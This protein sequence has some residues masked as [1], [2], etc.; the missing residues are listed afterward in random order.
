MFA[1]KPKFLPIPWYGTPFFPNPELTINSYILKDHTY[2]VICPYNCWLWMSCC[3]TGKVVCMSS[4]YNSCYRRVDDFW[5]TY[6]TTETKTLFTRGVQV[7]DK[8]TT[9]WL[10]DRQLCLLTTL[11]TC[12]I[13]Y[14]KHAVFSRIDM[15]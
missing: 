8:K 14:S 6:L 3:Y 12:F 5:N 15:E 9:D 1:L 2:H 4:N 10:H 13:C 7:D 11:N